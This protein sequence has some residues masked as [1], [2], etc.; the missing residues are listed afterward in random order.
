MDANE[1]EL[2]QARA[3]LNGNAELRSAIG[4]PDGACLEPRYL[5]VGEHNLNYRFREPA[6]GRDY[7]LRVNV[8]KQPFHSNQVAYEFAALRALEPSGRTPEPIYL[9]SSDGAPREGAMVI[10]FCEGEQLDFDNLRPGDLRCAA[11]LMADVHAVPM[12]EGCPIFRPDD[13]LRAL[14]EECLGRF[15]IYRT[16]AFEDA[17]ITKWV[18]AFIDAAERATRTPRRREDCAHIVNTETLPSHFLIPG[19]SARQAAGNAAASGPFCERPGWFIDWERPIVGEVAQDVAYFVSPTTTFWD[20]DFLFPQSGIDAFVEDYWRAVGGRFER[21]GFDERLRA[22]RIMT[23]LRSTT[24]CCRAL[25]TY[26]KPGAHKTE[27]TARKLPIYL[28]DE[29]LERL[30]VEVFEL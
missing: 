8:A 3:Y 11:Q 13:P 14:F 2:Q 24:W 5:G 28:D 10:G 19:A 12:K 27:R 22:W 9:D 26:S 23:A 17:R 1:R 6:S 21:G 15:E 18:E 4:A 16:S 25:V 7:V 29:F 30:A 20:S